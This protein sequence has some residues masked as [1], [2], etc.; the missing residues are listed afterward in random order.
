MYI[1]FKLTAHVPSVYWEYTE[2]ELIYELDKETS[3]FGI[4]T[5]VLRDTTERQELMENGTLILAGTKTQDIL[6]AFHSIDKMNMAWPML[7]DYHKEN[8]SDTVIRLLM[9]QSCKITRKGHD[10]Y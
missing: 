7:G 4:P 3:L 10:E 2:V 6:N 8:V 1:K 9:G 5:I